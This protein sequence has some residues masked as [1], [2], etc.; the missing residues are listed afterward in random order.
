MD[1]S[2]KKVI[3]LLSVALALG[4]CSSNTT[5]KVENTDPLPGFALSNLDTTAAPCTDFFQYVSGGLG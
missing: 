2:V 1:Q 4:A 3:G 5:T